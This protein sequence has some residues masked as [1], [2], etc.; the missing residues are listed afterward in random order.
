MLSIAV[1]IQKNLINS[2]NE[3]ILKY[4]D[5]KKWDVI[6]AN[7]P[8]NLANKML[9]KYFEIG[10][11][12]CTVQPSTW[13]L[14]KQQKKDIVKH[15]DTWDYSDI[16]SINGIEFFDATINGVMA[17]QMFK[18]NNPINHNRR[19]ILFDGK[20][21]DKCNEISTIS[22]DP[23]LTEFKKIVEPLYLKDNI[24]NYIYKKS[25]AKGFSSCPINMHPNINAYIY[26]L[27]SLRGHK[28][29]NDFFTIISNDDK[30]VNMRKGIYKDINNIIIDVDDKKGNYYK[31]SI[32]EY[33]ITFNN[34][35]ELNNFIE[36]IKTYFVRCCL[37]L[38]KHNMHLDSG[39]L[40]AIPMFDFSD[41]LFNNTV[42]DIDIQLFKKYNISQNIVNHILKIL[43]NYYNLDLNKYKNIKVEN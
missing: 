40:K 29:T 2:I 4:N 33:Y 39:E 27:N 21:Y 6:L 9:A 41:S 14:G 26:A 32:L 22:N 34:E 31:K 36:Y 11:E 3:K 19:Y 28:G 8:Y 10:S 15:V 38:V 16:E 24:Q 1:S 5:M 23:L 13:L 42:E 20:K 17:I 25:N 12:I 35:K 18:E 7:P 37:Y 30:K 43:P